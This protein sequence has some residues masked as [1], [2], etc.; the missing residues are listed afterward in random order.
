M[1]S[2]NELWKKSKFELQK[3]QTEKLRSIKIVNEIEKKLC[4]KQSQQTVVNASKNK[5]PTNNF[6]FSRIEEKKTTLNL[7]DFE[8]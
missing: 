3:L 2:K 5:K 6:Q 8:S 1:T 4:F 7:L